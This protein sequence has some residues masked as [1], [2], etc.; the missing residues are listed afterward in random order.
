[1]QGYWCVTNLCVSAFV[2]PQAEL[3]T[4]IRAHCEWAQSG[5]YNGEAFL[6]GG[7]CVKKDGVN[8]PIGHPE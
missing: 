6:S 7:S 2:A 8:I 4:D 5:H 1:M 3:T